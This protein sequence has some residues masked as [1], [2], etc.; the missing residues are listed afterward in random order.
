MRITTVE[1]SR[2]KYSFAGVFVSMLV[3]CKLFS[4]QILVEYT[5]VSSCYSVR[6][7]LAMVTLALI[8]LIAVT[9]GSCEAN[10]DKKE[11]RKNDHP[12]KSLWKKEYEDE[13]TDAMLSSR[14]KDNV[15]RVVQS[16]SVSDNEAVI[17]KL[18]ET[19]T[20]SE[21]YLKK[22]DSIDFRLNRL[23]IEVHEKTN[24]I[25]KQLMEL[26]K[27]VRSDA[28]PEKLEGALETLKNEVNQIKFMMEKLPRSNIA[29]NDESHIKI[30]DTSY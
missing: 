7:H 19:I 13:L 11:R 21:K 15:T 16:A 17:D 10:R 27:V 30:I 23:D 20:S 8:V 18:M 28:Y 25:L 22:V 26:M 4:H 2:L 14:K 1:E 6:S 9:T 24:N 3:V 5:T 12:D 29:G